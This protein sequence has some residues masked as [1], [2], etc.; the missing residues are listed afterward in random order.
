MPD[1][2][3]QIGAMIGLGVGID[4]ALF[5][6]TRFREYLHQGHDPQ[7]ATMAAIDTA[8]RAVVFAG[9]T[10][11]VSLLGLLLIGL[12]FVAGLGV[13]AAITVAVTMAASTTLLPALLGFA[14]LK[15]EITRWRGLVAAGCVSVAL[16]GAGL[17][18]HALLLG[19]PLALVVLVVGSFV[20][21]L[22]REVPAPHAEAGARERLVPVEP[23]HPA[24]ALALRHRRHAAP[25]RRS[26]C[27]CSASASASPT[28]A[29][30][31]RRPPPARPTTC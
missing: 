9:V 2:A 15:V 10:V 3:L 29:T 14:Q 25:A 30:T 20:P 4:Y 26:P 7:V 16:L 12:E 28:R 11:V 23:P 1:F 21:V 27:R 8:G 18:I 17:G 19:V 22:R 13:A 6:V 24:T 5:I 31:R